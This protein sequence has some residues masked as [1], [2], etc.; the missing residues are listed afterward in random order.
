MR[1]GLQLTAY[2][3]LDGATGSAATD[4]NSLYLFAWLAF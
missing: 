1:F 2:D 4:A 3:K